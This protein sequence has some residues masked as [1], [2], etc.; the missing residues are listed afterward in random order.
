MINQL[1]IINQLLIRK[2][3]CSC[4]PL[5]PLIYSSVV[6]VSLDK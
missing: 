6:F 2:E 1:F 3:I 5:L 4:V